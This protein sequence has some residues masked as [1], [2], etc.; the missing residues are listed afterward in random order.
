MNAALAEAEQLQKARLKAEFG[1]LRRYGFNTLFQWR[2]D[3]DMTPEVTEGLKVVLAEEEIKKVYPQDPWPPP[4]VHKVEYRKAAYLY[5]LA[6]F[7]EATAEELRQQGYAVRF[8]W[9][10]AWEDLQQEAGLNR[11]ES[12]LFMW[13]LG[14]KGCVHNPWHCSWGNPYHPFDGHS[15]EWGSYSQPG[16][17]P[18]P[19]I[20]SS[21]VLEGAREG[22]QDYRW[23]VTLERLAKARAGT[24]AG[25]TAQAYLAEL[26]KKI[27]PDATFYFQGV[28]LGKG[29][30]WGQTW[31]Q[32]PSAWK[33]GDYRDARRK[34]AEL[35]ASMG[36]A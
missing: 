10:L 1:L 2:E 33:G 12:G 31:S 5:T 13:R 30:G 25:D 29:S 34:M 22:I 6:K 18:W 36:G 21:A 9:I 16:S 15:G 26:R 35:I 8:N 28:G 20:N 7:N 32:K 23:V 11:F 14:A 24:P 4:P 19:A 3:K 17:G 27:T